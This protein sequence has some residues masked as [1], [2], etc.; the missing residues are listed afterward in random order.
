MENLVAA[1]SNFSAARIRPKMPSWM[2]SSSD[3]S[4]PWYFFAIET[5]RRRFELIMRSLAARSPCSMRFA[6]SISSVAVSGG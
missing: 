3:S 2:R 6:S 1:Q 4:W 5:T